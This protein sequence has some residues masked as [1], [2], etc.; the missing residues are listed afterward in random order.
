MNIACNQMRDKF[1]FSGTASPNLFV[2]EITVKYNNALQIKFCS[3]MLKAYLAVLFNYADVKV[4]D[5]VSRGLGKLFQ[6]S[7]CP[8]VSGLCLWVGL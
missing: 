2:P 7:L 8:F 3:C 6:W 5:C 4:R 1:I